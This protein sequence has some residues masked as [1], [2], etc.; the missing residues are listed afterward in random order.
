M[1]H[2]KY[3]TFIGYGYT[4]S[5]IQY[6]AA[7]FARSIGKQV[8][9]EKGLSDHWFYGSLKRWSDLKMAKPLKL[10]ISRAKGTTKEVIDKYFSELRNVTR[11]NGLIEAPQ[12][13]YNC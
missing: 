12:R 8:K 11:D 5:K 1:E 9:A 2:V 3:M 6:M 4:K 7:D 13:I 10:Q